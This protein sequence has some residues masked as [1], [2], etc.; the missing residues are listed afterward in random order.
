[1]PN[2]PRSIVLIGMMGA[3]KSSV[4][5]CLQRK[6][7][8]QI[9]DIDELVSAKA[10]C[11][12]PEIF[13]KHGEPHFR[14]LESEALDQVSTAEPAIIVTGGG[15]ILREKNVARLQELGLVV[16]LAADESVL[17][18]RAGRRG[19]RPLLQTND[20]K[21]TIAELSRVR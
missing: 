3:G 20:P 4:G 15:V 7:G 10:G 13:A 16:W 6:T 17:F 14:E 11:P 19:N 9:F 1:M 5:R 8:L 2:N 12:I 18:A 21:A